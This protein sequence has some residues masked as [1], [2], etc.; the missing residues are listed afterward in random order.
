MILTTGDE[1]VS[2]QP[3]PDGRGG[4]GPA[5]ARRV[6]PLLRAHVPL[7]GQRARGEVL[8]ELVRI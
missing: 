2:D 1:R 3:V 6:H 5:A 4:G 7:D 8:M